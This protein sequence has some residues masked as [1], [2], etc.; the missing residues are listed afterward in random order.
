MEGTI[1]MEGGSEKPLEISKLKM[2]IK[3][4][5]GFVYSPARFLEDMM[6]MMGAPVRART[7]A[8]PRKGA[9]PLPSHRS[10]ETWGTWHCGVW[11][12]K[13]ERV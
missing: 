13:W 5:V 1:K 6:A 10:P 9:C 2:S 7:W 4:G 12:R 8:S 11:K 3:E